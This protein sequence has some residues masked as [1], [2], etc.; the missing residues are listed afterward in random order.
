MRKIKY[1]KVYCWNITSQN[2]IGWGM[3]FEEIIIWWHNQR[4][5]QYM[6]I[7]FVKQWCHD[8][9]DM[10]HCDPTQKNN[11]FFYFHGFTP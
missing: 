9:V 11:Y 3:R 2:W 7:E 6:P 1:P 10:S 5:K 8:L 4:E